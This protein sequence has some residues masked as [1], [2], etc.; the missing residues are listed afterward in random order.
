MSEPDVDQE[1]L[2]ENRDNVLWLTL[3]R[4]DAGN[5]ITPAVRNRMIEHLADASSSYDVRGDRAHRGRREALLHG[6]GSPRRA[7]DAAA[8]TRGCPRT[9]GRRGRADDPHRHPAAD[10]GDARLRQADHRGRE[11]DRRGRRCRDGARVGP[12]DRG[13]ARAHHPGVRSSRPHPRRRRHLSPSAPGRPP[14]REGARVLRRRPRA[15]PTPSGSA[16]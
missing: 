2:A 5:A 9:T 14:P 12:G 10:R 8:A 13:G 15:R 4:P 6:C 1:L 7:G 11:R 3:N 16:W